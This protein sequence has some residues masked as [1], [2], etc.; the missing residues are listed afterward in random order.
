MFFKGLGLKILPGFLPGL[1][2]AY[3]NHIWPDFM[4]YINRTA[5]L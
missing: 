4:P 1:F 5:T 2:Y 3:Y